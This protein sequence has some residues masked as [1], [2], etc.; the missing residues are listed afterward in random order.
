MYL[1]T[2]KNLRAGAGA[3]ACLFGAAGASFNILGTI[4]D[5]HSLPIKGADVNVICGGTA[6]RTVTHRDGSFA[7]SS[8]ARAGCSL[9]VS[10]PGFATAVQP[11]IGGTR[12]Y[13]IR[14]A[15]G[16]A[17]KTQITV[18]ANSPLQTVSDLTQFTSSDLRNVSDRVSD[19]IHYAKSISGAGQADDRIYVNG[20][21]AS[22]MPPAEMISRID[23]NTDPFSAEYADGDGNHI[24]I[25]TKGGSRRTHASLNGTPFGTVIRNSLDPSSRSESSSASA[26]IRGPIPGLPLTFSARANFSANLNETPIRAILPDRGLINGTTTGTKAASRGQM[27]SVSADANYSMSDTG[28]A[29]LTFNS[30]KLTGTH[31]GAGGITLTESGFRSENSGFD[32]QGTIAIDTALGSYRGGLSV[33]HVNTSLHAD[34]EAAGLTILDSV[35]AGGAALTQSRSAG[36]RWTVKNV[37]DSKFRSRALLVGLVVSGAQDFRRDAPNPNG[38]FQFESIR[39][40]DEALNGKPTAT[41]YGLS[42]EGTVRYRS[43]FAAPFVQGELL[44]REHVLV[45]GGIRA[46]YQAGLGTIFSPRLSLAA[47]GRGL[48]FRSGGGLFVREIG[49]PLFMKAIGGDRY[50]LR[51]AIQKGVSLGSTELRPEIQARAAYW[52]IDPH[53]TRPRQWMTK[54]SVERSLRGFT[55]GFDHTWTRHRHLPGARRL[56]DGM[57]WMDLLESNRSAERHRLHTRLSYRRKMQ[58]VFANYEWVH[59]RDNSDGPFAFPALQDSLRNEWAR[60]ASLARHNVSL[61]G[62]FQLPMAVTFTLIGSFHGSAPYNITSGLDPFGN[63]LYTDRGGRPRNSGDGPSFNTVSVYAHRRI[64]LPRFVTRSA[65]PVHVHAGIQGDNLMGSTNYSSVG[66]VAGSGNFG[67][68]VAALPGRSMRVW[69]NFE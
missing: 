42:G 58:S 24:A 39:D 13:H 54:T 22:R 66:T 65:K 2:V 40:Y 53:L 51:Q 27:G 30:Y 20:L 64:A 12:F 37:L 60:S 15:L 62:S 45:Q 36:E 43:L 18:K 10:A 3:F 19:W 7:L 47:R 6:A 29:H 25:T 28:N 68:A 56:P 5:S 11:V 44:Q 17:P 63:G 61:V 49:N 32:A 16:N 1:T 21:P 26:A 50:H 48:V 59:G 46:D 41:W 35:I 14:L 55:S 57:G 67:R 52:Q 8:D 69:F 4:V 33:S 34:S 38:M 31:V 9:S 23:I